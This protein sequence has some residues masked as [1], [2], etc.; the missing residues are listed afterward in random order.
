[1][2]KLKIQ[3]D[4]NE[5]KIEFMSINFIVQKKDR[6]RRYLKVLSS[7]ASSEPMNSR[8]AKITR[9]AD[10]A[11]TSSQAGNLFCQTREFPSD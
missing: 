10:L 5:V 11:A 7:G 2:K 8:F 9:S 3:N 4:L 1:M 6:S